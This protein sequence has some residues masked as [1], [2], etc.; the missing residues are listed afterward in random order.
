MIGFYRRDIPMG[1]EWVIRVGLSR[2]AKVGGPLLTGEN[3]IFD[4]GPTIP[5]AAANATVASQ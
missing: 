4:L 1:H 5:N 3:Q 2:S